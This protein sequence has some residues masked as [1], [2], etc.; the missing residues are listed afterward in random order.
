MAFLFLPRPLFGTHL[1][2]PFLPR[3]LFVFFFGTYFGLKIVLS[4]KIEPTFF[5]LVIEKPTFSDLK[6]T[7]RS[8]SKPTFSY[9][10]PTLIVFPKPGL[11]IAMGLTVQGCPRVALR[12]P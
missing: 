9:R 12:V 2:F 3:A 8:L 6:P 1:D 5:I 10:K 4:I 7:L 11:S